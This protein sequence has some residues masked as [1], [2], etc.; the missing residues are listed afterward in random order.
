MKE[1]RLPETCLVL[2]VGPSSSGKSTFGKKYFLP[3]EVVSSDTCR[4]LVADNENDMAATG[5]AFDILHVIAAARLKYGKLTVIDALNVRKEDRAKLVKLAKDNYALSVAIVLENSL[6][7]LFERHEKRSDRS[8]AKGVL[9]RQHEDFKNSMRTIEKEGFSYVYYV[10][11]AEELRLVRHK[12]YNNKKEELGPF[13]II[14]DIHGCYDELHALL[15]KLGYS[16]EKA[17]GHFKA[18]HPQN[19]KVIF[20][21]D[22]TDRGPNSCDVLRL[23]IDMVKEGKAYCIN[24]NH[25]EKLN[26]YLAG[27]NVAIN[28][29]LEKTVQQ[30]ES[31]SKEFRSEVKEFLY[32]L[33]SHYVLDEGRLVVAHG[34]LPEEMHGR[35]ASAVRSFCM[36]GETTGEVDEFGLPVRYKWAKD[37]KGK[38]FVVY[39][40]TPIP[41]PE[42]LNN[43]LN[44][45]T[46]C[47]FGGQLTALRYPEKEL[48]SV[49][50]LQ[51]Y[52]EP[53]RPLRP[54][55]EQLTAQQ[56]LDELLDI[57][58]ISGKKLIETRFQCKV[59]LRE[60]NAI[61]ALETISRFSLN[62]KWLIYLPPTMSPPETSASPNYLEHP[63]EVFHYYSKNGVTDLICEEKHMGSRAIAIVCKDPEVAVKRFGLLQPSYGT[64]YTR[65]GR[66]FFQQEQIE[67][68]FLQILHEALTK[69]HFWAKF[70]TDWVCL[71]GELMP[72]N[73][74]AKDLLINQY[75]SLGSAGMNSFDHSL[76]ALKRAQLRGIAVDELLD[77]FSDRQ[78]RLSRYISSYRNYCRET[79]GIEKV[80]FAP[81]H[82]L[83]TENRTYYQQSHL[84]HMEKLEEICKQN[85]KHLLATQTIQVDLQ[86][87]D[88]IKRAIDWWIALTT[89]C[90][91][92]MVVKPRDYIATNKGKPIQPAIK[93]RGRE[94]LRLIYGPEYDTEANLAVLKDRNVKIK[95]DLALREFSLGLE[96]LCRFVSKEPLRR[97]HECVFGVLA[98]ESEYVDP[99][100]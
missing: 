62:P 86:S 53:V 58:S 98:L 49:D 77:S 61:A 13:D 79:E 24:G 73:M 54:L 25:D 96:S 37:Y 70:E 69:A 29:G 33:H 95:R 34:G 56:E 66:R 88:S 15:L 93:C 22:L 5:A 90:G 40:H 30:F 44:I 83:A 74:K 12:L 27:K 16:I 68:A 43:T 9:A 89:N 84:W 65:T 7:E 59:I 50:A 76:Q 78:E 19:R 26:R 99:R 72:W 63:E 32:S 87:E 91:E 100:L 23:V 1:L 48:V 6:S 85:P 80:V 92:G 64:I 10:N 81:F 31:A 38:A 4:A 94:Y 8:F 97:V 46:G 21:G 75:A 14:G 60:E 28:H 82:I 41:E 11:P 45:D 55:K 35:A 51:V 18:L 39:G 20:L 17:D 71:D 47:A 42:W 36:Y 57:E 67:K 52:Y 3:T 2:L